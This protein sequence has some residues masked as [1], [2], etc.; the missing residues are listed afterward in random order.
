[1]QS[2][3]DRVLEIGNWRVSGRGE[4]RR[5]ELSNNSLP[6]GGVEAPTHRDRRRKVSLSR[7]QLAALLE[8]GAVRNRSQLATY[9]GISRAR[10]TQILGAKGVSEVVQ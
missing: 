8:T 1:M 3:D 4:N 6:G 5:L 2:L 7:E 10:V 9:L